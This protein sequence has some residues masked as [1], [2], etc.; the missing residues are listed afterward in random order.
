MPSDEQASAPDSLGRFA[1]EYLAAG[2]AARA[3]MLPALVSLHGDRAAPVLVDVL[4][5]SSGVNRSVEQALVD[6]GRAGARLLVAAY[7]ERA[8]LRR[9][10]ADAVARVAGEEGLPALAEALADDLS[11]VR[12]AAAEAIASLGPSATPFL[13]DVLTTADHIGRGDALAALERIGDPRALPVI[14]AR[15]EDPDP[16]VAR[17]AVGALARVDT[18]DAIA[19]L[20][21]CC[22]APRPAVRRW[23]A[24][25]LARTRARGVGALLDGLA[26]RDRDPAARRAAIAAMIVVLRRES[27]PGL[28]RTLV[29][30]LVDGDASVRRAAEDALAA[31]AETALAFLS[32]LPAADREHPRVGAVRDRIAGE[33]VARERNR[34]VM[35]DVASEGPEP[36]PTLEPPTLSPDAVQFT[37]S[38]PAAAARGEPFELDVVAHV[39]AFGPRADGRLA[40]RTAGPYPVLPGSAMT[41]QVAIPT[42]AFADA[43]VL[44]WLEQEG[45]A[46]FVVPVADDAAPGRHAGAL[47]VSV[48][49]LRVARVRFVIDVGGRD[50]RRQRVNSALSRVQSAFASY[51]S[52]DR[53]LVLGRIQGIRKVL[54]DIDVFM[55]VVSL[56]SGERWRERLAE[57]IGA[58]DTMFLFWS[59]SARRSTWVDFEWR[60]ALRVRGEDFID[61]IPL[62]RPETAP[63]PPELSH[64][65][66]GDPALYLHSPPAPPA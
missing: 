12:A 62:E 55:D 2:Y 28:F 63:P 25:A 36:E 57:E 40:V 43:E 21:A 50:A 27:S 30:L 47:D 10:H 37:V 20:R 5:R 51:A 65:H 19:A 24:G 6:V 58:R 33:V 14:V 23:A 16:E 22:G 38:A 48:G 54:P 44:V 8:A 4:T 53:D 26:L 42:L 7:R 13:V 61:P 39:G 46:A 18:A 35:H 34:N 59:S 45:T 49:G 52:E 66:F 15:T 17:A 56:R 64:K 9:R 41:L 1:E 60:L 3:A 11:D 32:A 31:L 29:A